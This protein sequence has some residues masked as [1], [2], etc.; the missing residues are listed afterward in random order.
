[1][2]SSA[3]PSQAYIP[4]PWCSDGL[5]SN[6]GGNDCSFSSYQ[7]RKENARACIANP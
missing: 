3:A 2:L 6:P 7:Q 4:R 5:S 1:L